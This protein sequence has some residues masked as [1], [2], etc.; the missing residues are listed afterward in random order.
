MKLPKLKKRL[1]PGQWRRRLAQAARR[2]ER[3]LTADLRTWER[4]RR[5]RASR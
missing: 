1:A 2:A 3:R 4:P 5:A